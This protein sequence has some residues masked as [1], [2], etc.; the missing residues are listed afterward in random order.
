MTQAHILVVEDETAVREAI[1]DT[2]AAYRLGLAATMDEALIY[3]QAHSVDLVLLDLQLGADNGMRVAQ[4]IR[5]QSPYVAIVILTG[6]GS[7]Q[8]AI[9]AI[10]LDAQAYLLKPVTP[11]ELER[12]VA[13]QMAR[14]DEVR[15]RDELAR[16]MRQAVE[17]IHSRIEPMPENHLASGKLVMNRSRYEA[18]YNG[19]QVALSSTQFRLLW[20]LVEAEGEIVTAKKLASEAMGYD[21]RDSDAS[22]LVRGHISK[23]R[24]QLAIHAGKKTHIRTIRNQGYIWVD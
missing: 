2:L 15:Q 3:L 18:S 16:H 11:D 17:A 22:E 5:S 7:L 4:H 1:R 12:V 6:H 24:H 14:M 19:G 21:V 10:E 8:S 13:E 9:R 20:A 23:I